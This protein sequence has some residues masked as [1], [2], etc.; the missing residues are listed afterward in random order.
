METQA[1]N[2]SAAAT[3]EAA[4]DWRA[5]LKV[6]RVGAYVWRI[7][8]DL[9]GSE[10]WLS[11]P[12]HNLADDANLLKR[13]IPGSGTRVARMA[14]S[15][16]R[17]VLKE[18]RAPGLRKICEALIRGPRAV[19]TFQ[20]L[21]RLQR[22]GIAAIRPLAAAHEWGKPWHSILVTEQL[23][24]SERLYDY[25]AHSRRHRS[26]TIPPLARILA[27]LHNAGFLH[28]DAHHANFL[29][30]VENAPELYLVDV[31][32]MRE[33]RKVTLRHAV[34]DIS[35]LLL[36]LQ[37]PKQER[38][39]FALVYCRERNPPLAPRQFVSLFDR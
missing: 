22:L 25:A 11:H 29:V 4:E 39:R 3:V 2:D 26:K 36:H 15:T 13:P 19:R 18:Y 1:Q 37:I 10:H 5:Q 31:D 24:L 30:K 20:M 6:L 27:A 32:G 14:A 34:R 21:F 12:E 28:G 17:F 35:R 8:K 7:A 23:A 38:L 9:S 16:G 33:A